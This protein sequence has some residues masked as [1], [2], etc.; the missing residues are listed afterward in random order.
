VKVCTLFIALIKIS[1]NSGVKWMI[2]AI[3]LLELSFLK[4]KCVVAMM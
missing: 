4:F 1:G 2:C 3:T